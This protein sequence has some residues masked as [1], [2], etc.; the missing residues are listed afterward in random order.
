MD[1]KPFLKH[2]HL[3]NPLCYVRAC[4]WEEQRAVL[5][6]LM[7]FHSHGAQVIFKYE[8]VSMLFFSL[9]AVSWMIFMKLFVHILALPVWKQTWRLKC[10]E[11]NL[12][13]W[14]QFRSGWKEDALKILMECLFLSKFSLDLQTKDLF[15]LMDQIF[16]SFLDHTDI[17]NLTPN[18]TL[19]FGNVCR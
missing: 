5:W 11:K 2:Y 1:L 8:K 14:R 17:A 6:G 13:S 7:V 9:F 3:L 4:L 19:R 18:W 16:F 12:L 10:H 15:W